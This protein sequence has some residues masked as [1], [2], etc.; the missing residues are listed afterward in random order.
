MILL[1]LPE[2]FELSGRCIKE[3]T[4]AARTKTLTFKRTLSAPAQEVYRAF[5]NATALR[6][7]L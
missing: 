2:S 6:E 4:M 5:T 3:A 1:H 7:W